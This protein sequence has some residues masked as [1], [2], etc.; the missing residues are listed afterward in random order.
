M[1]IDVVDNRGV[2]SMAVE[3]K[4]RF[5]EFDD[6]RMATA[7]LTREGLAELELALGRGRKSLRVKLLVGLYNGHTEAAALRKLLALQKRAVSPLEVKI[8]Q[9]ARFHWKV[10]IFGGQQRRVAY[11]G[12]S[13]LTR[14]GL[15]AEGE[16]N[17]RLSGTSTDL[18]LVNITDTFDRSWRKDAVPL[19]QNISDK[20]APVSQRSRNISR[21]IDPQISRLLR[22]IPRP[23]LNVTRTV[24]GE[25]SYYT[26]VDE[27]AESS[28]Q[29]NVREK[30]RWDSNGWDWMVCRTKSDRDRLLEAGSFYLAEIHRNGGTLSI[31]DVRDDDEFGTADGRFFVAYQKRRGSIAK[32]LKA[33]T[34]RVLRNG[35][36]ILRKEDLCRNRTIG[37]QKRSLLNKLLK[38]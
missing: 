19:N 11:V 33:K 32:S 37:L 3:L 4:A 24:R 30:T 6:V 36:F 15:G 8:A 12:S 22:H 23:A 38:A 7:S 21:G 2:T 16:F 29:Q 31:N 1:M 28:T 14:D 9:N 10:Y 27:F 13:N 18:C 20:F 5:Q 26:F 25:A 17:L 35:G 34:L